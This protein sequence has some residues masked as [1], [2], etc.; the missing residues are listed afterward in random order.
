MLGGIL[1]RN[2]SRS[3]GCSY[4][5][6]TAFPKL[7]RPFTHSP[8][9]FHKIPTDGTSTPIGH[10]DPRLQIS[11]TCTVKDCGERS[12]HEFAKSSYTKGIV[13]VQCPGC[14]NRHLIADNL[15]W[16]KQPDTAQGELRTVED[17]MRAKGEKVRRG[18]LQQGGETIEFSD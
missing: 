12:T 3:V 15:G 10:A 11:F 16:F 8:T 2:I 13:I 7:T 9:R 17:L 14:S 4:R 5:A 1:R 6:A 18:V